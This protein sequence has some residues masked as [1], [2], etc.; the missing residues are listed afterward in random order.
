MGIKD[1]FRRKD[2]PGPPDAVDQAQA[3]AATDP[4]GAFRLL[5]PVIAYPAT[6]DDNAAFSR[7]FKVFAGIANGLGEPSFGALVSAAAARPNN[8]QAVFDAG[9][10]AY[11]SGV[12]DVAAT[13]FLRANRLQPGVPQIVSEAAG[14][15]ENLLRYREAYDV[16]EASG[17][18]DSDPICAYL[19]GYCAL[20]R[21]DRERT[22]RALA[23]LA[24]A[25]DAPVVDIRDRLASML[26]RSDALAD[27][28]LLAP[29]ALTAWHMALNGTLL[30][31]ESPHGYPALR[32]C[33]R[34]R[35]PDARGHRAFAGR[36]GRP[37][38]AARGP[39]ARPRQPHSG[40]RRGAALWSV[41]GGVVGRRGRA[42][43]RPRRGLDARRRGRRGLPPRGEDGMRYYMPLAR[44][45]FGTTSTAST[46]TSSCAGSTS[47]AAAR[48]P[49]VSSGMLTFR[50]SMRCRYASAS[51]AASAIFSCDQPRACRS[52]RSRAA[53]RSRSSRTGWDS[54][55]RTTQSSC[56]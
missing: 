38:A 11:E 52:N 12:F 17:L 42:R 46:G 26:V 2:P 9:Y 56:V 48:R 53:T 33:Q 45:P 7:A 31:H 6:L 23:V 1:W 54:G 8:V 3:L 36:V 32:V 50:H 24:D 19:A 40:A 30:L 47:K 16:L 15:L 28:G 41:R 25:E 43:E 39:C 21:G 10:Q 55:V 35:R 18:A 37:A 51:P 5:R 14:A 34:Q 27:A 29:D 4:Q 13:L 44:A 49:S 22:R 20:M